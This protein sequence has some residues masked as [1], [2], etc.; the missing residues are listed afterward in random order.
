MKEKQL[1]ETGFAY[2]GYYVKAC[3]IHG[4]AITKS[5]YFIGWAK[6]RSE[7]LSTIDSLV[8]ERP[9]NLWGQSVAPHGQLAPQKAYHSR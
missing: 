4:L 2:R 3:G 9:T 1:V 5:E 8:G 6:T 7:A